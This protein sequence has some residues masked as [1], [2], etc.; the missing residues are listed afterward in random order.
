M[1]AL[2][3]GPGLTEGGTARVAYKTGKAPLFLVPLLVGAL[4]SSLAFLLSLSVDLSDGARVAI[5]GSAV[6]GPITIILILRNFVLGVYL[7]GAVLPFENQVIFGSLASST[8]AIAFL[9]FASCALTLLRDRKLFARLWH[10]LHNPVVISLFAL[11]LWCLA[12]TV[13]AYDQGAALTKASTFLGLFGLTLV[14]A[15]LDRGQVTLLWIVLATSS[16]LSILYGFVGYLLRPAPDEPY[17]T[18]AGVDPTRVSSAGADPNDYAGFILIVFLVVYYGLP[19]R[20]ILARYALAIVTFLGIFASQSRAG[21]VALIVTPLLGLFGPALKARFAIRSLVMLGLA[22][23]VLIGFIY[24]SAHLMGGEDVRMGE[25]VL[26]RYAA[27]SQI[28]N[29]NTWTGRLDL[30][31]GALEIISSHPLLGI[32]AG[33]FFYG[34]SRVSAEAARL[35]NVTGTGA[36]AHN[37]FL[38]VWSE[39]GTVGLGLFLGMLVLAFQQALTLVRRNSNLGASLV[40]GLVAYIIM[41]MT[42]TWEHEELPYLLYGSILSLQLHETTRHKTQTLSAKNN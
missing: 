41:G 14:V 24:Y 23:L 42:L 17:D 40:F 18:L 7:F 39:L 8:K 26:K 16:F 29:E 19:R 22:A 30:W 12:S 11:S 37:M 31:Q 28:R 4:L 13:W 34:A 15:L 3:L 38:S 36:V 2:R 6:A 35:E 27:L 33:N 1:R 10:L 25:G 5:V 20:F 21:L 9:M 32:G